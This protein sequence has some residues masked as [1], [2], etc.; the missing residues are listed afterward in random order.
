M[1]PGI[2]TKTPDSNISF[3]NLTSKRIATRRGQ[4]SLSC[5]YAVISV[6]SVVWRF[7]NQSLY[8]STLVLPSFSFHIKSTWKAWKHWHFLSQGSTCAYLSTLG[9]LRYFKIRDFAGLLIFWRGRRG[10]FYVL[11]K[12]PFILNKNVQQF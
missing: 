4:S 9:F 6:Q 5:K 12:Q 2:C 1:V 7:S 11:R 8:R 3:W 10:L